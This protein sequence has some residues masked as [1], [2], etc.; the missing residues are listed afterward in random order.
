LKGILTLLKN[1]L[2]TLPARPE[3]YRSKL[4]FFLFLASLGMFFLGSLVSYCVI[5]ANA[6]REDGIRQYVPLDLPISFWIST[7]LL[8]GV[9]ICLHRSCYLVHRQKLGSFRVWLWTAA[10]FGI[11]FCAIQAFGM[12]FLLDVHFSASD[13]STKSYGICFTLA[14][15]HALHVLGGIIFLVVVVLGDRR[16]KFDHE[17]HWAVDN[18]ANYWHFLDVVWIAM[19]ATFL[20]AR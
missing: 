3:A 4:V 7:L 19:L 20:I 13:G 17:R 9:S 5:R 14:L 16:Q 18:C 10:G 15:V 2:S 8:V 1:T 6:F 11:A 12:I